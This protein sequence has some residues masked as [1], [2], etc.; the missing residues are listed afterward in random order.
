[1]CLG[2]CE[3]NRNFCGPA[4]ALNIL[5]KVEFSLEHL[6]VKKQQR[7]ESL[8]LSGCRDAFFDRKMS[9]KFGDF[10]LAHFVW[11]AFAMK[12]N[13]TANPIDIRLLSADGVMFDA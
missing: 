3:N 8:V 4:D 13:V 1:V 7:A 12:E 11:V 5:D 6:L 2:A 10:F 9:E